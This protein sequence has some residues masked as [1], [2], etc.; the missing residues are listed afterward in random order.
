MEK[1]NQGFDN[2][3]KLLPPPERKLSKAAI[4]QQA[5]QHIKLLQRTVVQIKVENQD[6]KHRLDA[7]STSGDSVSTESPVKIYTTHSQDEFDETEMA[8]KNS[9]DSFEFSPITQQE[10]RRARFDS[11]S[12]RIAIRA[13]TDVSLNKSS[14]PNWPTNVFERNQKISPGMKSVQCYKKDY[15]GYGMSSMDYALP[16]RRP[17]SSFAHPFVRSNPQKT[18]PTLSSYKR[19]APYPCKPQASLQS[20]GKLSSTVTGRVHSFQP[21]LKTPQLPHQSTTNGPCCTVSQRRP[22]QSNLDTIVEAIK[23]IENNSFENTKFNVT[24]TM[25]S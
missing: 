18:L 10:K 5:V 21:T 19:I 25:F 16:A 7:Q 1:I 11:K 15:T 8:V 13:L 3:K 9:L 20:F 12:S 2:L 24:S 23:L 17:T 14:F 4:L 22:Q 6:L